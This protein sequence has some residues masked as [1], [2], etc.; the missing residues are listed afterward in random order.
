MRDAV[1]AYR[2]VVLVGGTSE[3]G[4]AILRRL[5]AQ[6]T[7]TVTLLSRDPG[8]A[9]ADLVGWDVSIT[10]ESLDLGEPSSF[11]SLARQCSTGSD[12][13]LVIVAA[14][15]LGDAEQAAHDPVHATELMDT[16]FAG[17]A[18]ITG[19]FADVLAA[20]GHG[21]I[22]VLSSVAGYRV[23]GDNHVYGAAKAGLDGYAQGLVQRLH[24]T[25][26]DVLIVR[27][28]FVHTR[29]TQGMDAAPFS[30]APDQVAEDVVTALRKGHAIA[31]SPGILKLVMGILRHL[32]AGVFRRAS[33]R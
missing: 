16:T 6:G 24:G 14:G 8:Q 22:V 13:D 10:S 9:S 18:A 7:R 23:R 12:I 5:V 28:G 31:W 17:P 25:G 19:A 20:Q 26:V 21:G 4:Q 30:V 32:P 29:M 15:M 3:I 27:P 11:T 33:A 1:G 2:H